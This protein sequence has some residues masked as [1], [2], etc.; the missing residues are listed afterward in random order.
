MVKD[1]LSFMYP[2]ILDLTI[3]PEIH[4]NIILECPVC[5]RKFNMTSIGDDLENARACA[6]AEIYHTHT[7][8]CIG[9]LQ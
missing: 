2:K 7:K 6:I 8:N 3:K 9:G 5:K 1:A 4:I